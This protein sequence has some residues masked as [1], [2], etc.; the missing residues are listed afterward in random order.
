[1]DFRLQN[2]RE[3]NELSQK[4]I[5]NILNVSQPTYCRWEKEVEIIP[6]KKLVL[7][8]KY[9]DISLDY[10]CNLSNI[11]KEAKEYD[12]KVNKEISGNNIVNFRKEHNITQKELA[13]FLNTTPS[14][15]CAYEKGKT[16][17]LTSFAYQICKKYNI[18]MDYICGIIKK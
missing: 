4:T 18:S 3:N 10:I 16:L 17:I 2:I 12:Y 7:F 14:T 8:A 15:I 1:M 6:L 13:F 5:A 11:R 9:F